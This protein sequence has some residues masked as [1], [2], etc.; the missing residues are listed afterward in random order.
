MD[1]PDHNPSAKNK[2]VFRKYGLGLAASTVL[3]GAGII[4]DRSQRPQRQGIPPPAPVVIPDAN[5]QE[6]SERYTRILELEQ[7]MARTTDPIE[8]DVYAR[9]HQSEHVIGMRNKELPE[10]LANNL[11][12]ESARQY[13]TLNPRKES[14]KG[15]LDRLD[16]VQS[17]LDT[18]ENKTRIPTPDIDLGPSYRQWDTIK[19][20][21][22]P[23]EEILIAGD[24]LKPQGTSR[25]QWNTERDFEYVRDYEYAQGYMLKRK[26]EQMSALGEL[27]VVADKSVIDAVELMK[28]PNPR[29]RN[30]PLAITAGVSYNPF[31]PEPAQLMQDLGHVKVTAKDGE[32]LTIRLNM[33]QGGQVMQALMENSDPA[34]WNPPNQKQKIELQRAADTQLQEVAPYLG[35]QMPSR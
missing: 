10:N 20:E 18:V 11:L 29:M 6:A 7:V 25:A 17:F 34:D 30:S 14:A 13:N 5:Q 21:L 23:Y 26:I 15:S 8:Q 27:H 24:V 9:L 4:A 31:N 19:R 32:A 28:N 3:L 16:A 2:S 35:G 12:Q 33:M 1:N 22:N